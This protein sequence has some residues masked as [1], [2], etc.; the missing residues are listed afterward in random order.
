MNFQ[1]KKGINFNFGFLGIVKELF[2]II[3]SLKELKI[4]IKNLII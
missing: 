3:I 4:R 1:R 2:F